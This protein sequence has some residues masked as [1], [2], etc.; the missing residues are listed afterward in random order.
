MNECKE[1][2]TWRFVNDELDD[3]WQFSGLIILNDKILLILEILVWWLRFVLFHELVL[4]QFWQQTQRERNKHKCLQMEILSSFFSQLFLVV[5]PSSSSSFWSYQIHS[6]I[7]FILWNSKFFG[8]YAETA[9][10]NKN[11]NINIP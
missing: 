8:S 1:K 11:I 9:K 5:S 2:K 3:L 6:F 7:T 4:N 10:K